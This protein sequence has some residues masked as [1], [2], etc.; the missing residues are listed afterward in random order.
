MNNDEFDINEIENFVN[1]EVVLNENV[2][3]NYIKKSFANSFV[4]HDMIEYEG[5]EFED[6]GF[7]TEDVPTIVIFGCYDNPN[8]FVS[9]HLFTYDHELEEEEPLSDTI[10]KFKKHIYRLKNIVNDMDFCMVSYPIL[11]DTLQYC[12]DSVYDY[13]LE[14]II[15]NERGFL[16]GAISKRSI[17]LR[18][19]KSSP[20]EVQFL[21]PDKDEFSYEDIKKQKGKKKNLEARAYAT[22]LE[23]F[24]SLPSFAS[25]DSLNS[26]IDEIKKDKMKIITH[27]DAI[28]KELKD[29]VASLPLDGFVL[30]DK[31]DHLQ[32]DEWKQVM[33]DLLAKTDVEKEEVSELIDL[34]NRY[35][36]AHRQEE[37]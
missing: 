7:S 37:E 11:A 25:E 23:N 22:V 30:I 27:S 29:K 4:V 20:I 33:L 10:E 28:K 36:E 16:G 34:V 1:S 5:M 19:D 35:M 13:G 32:T 9:M 12:N 26:L 18:D 24:Y 15:F 2:L 21:I 6:D 14:T 8:Q 17:S 31:A 3:G